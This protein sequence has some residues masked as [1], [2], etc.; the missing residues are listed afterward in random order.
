MCMFV[1]SGPLDGEIVK[2]VTLQT[3]VSLVLA[4][5]LTSRCVGTLMLKLI[6]PVL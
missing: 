5:S 2:E 4:M 1:L 3:Y 6:Q